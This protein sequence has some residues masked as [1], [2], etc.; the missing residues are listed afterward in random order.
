MWGLQLNLIITGSTWNKTYFN[1]P[2]H[3]IDHHVTESR[4][5]VDQLK[6]NERNCVAFVCTHNCINRSRRC[7]E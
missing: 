4:S 5:E 3:S 2:S 1:S 7:G 6:L